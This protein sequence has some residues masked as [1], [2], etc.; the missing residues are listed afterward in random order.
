MGMYES[1]FS[2]TVLGGPLELANVA[3]KSTNQWFGRTAVT[4]VAGGLAATVTCPMLDSDS[5]LM[6]TYD[7]TSVNVPPAFQ[8]GT[9]VRVPGVSFTLGSINSFS[10]N[11]SFSVTANWWLTNPASSVG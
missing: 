5:L 4:S 1:A 8:L 3:S 10:Y 6:V 11:G 7:I 9:K 2:R